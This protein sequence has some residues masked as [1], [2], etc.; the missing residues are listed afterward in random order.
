M[1]LELI[2]CTFEGTT[3][4]AEAKKAIQDLDEELDS[5]KLGN[6]AVLSKDATGKFTFSE[7]S[8][9]SAIAQGTTIGALCGAIVGM[10]A[11]PIGAAAGAAAG[12]AVGSAVG[13][14]DLGF[15]DSVLKKLGE[16]LQA[17]SSALITLLKPEERDVIAAELQN[18]GGDLIE[19]TLPADVVQKLIEAENN[20]GTK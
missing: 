14:I 4:A 19:H 20:L 15:P 1:M 17:G 7:T 3:K 16:Q 6:I 10:L 9:S 18:L 2:V 12:T 8:K 11:G 5:V 13:V